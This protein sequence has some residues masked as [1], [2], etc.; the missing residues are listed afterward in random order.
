MICTL[1]TAAFVCTLFTLG[2]VRAA[3]GQMAIRTTVEPP[4]EQ[5]TK[6][7]HALFV[8]DWQ[9]ISERY[10]EF[11]TYRGDLRYN[12]RLADV[13][14]AAQAADYAQARRVISAARAL[15]A[16][17]LN[18]T[19]RVS[20]ELFIR[21]AVEGL[22]LEPH[23]GYRSLSL[24]A[25]GG[26]QSDLSYLLRVVPMSRAEHVEQLL[27]RLAAYPKRMDQE[28]ANLGSGMTAGWVA[29]KAVLDRVVLQI[30]GQMP[31]D[32]EAGPFYEPFKR[33]GSNI[34]AA[35]RTRLQA[36]GRAAIEQHVLPSMKKL[37]AFVT[38][39]Y[40]PKAPASG[41]MLQYPD[42]KTVYD[43]LVRQQTTT[44]LSAAQVHAIGLR[45]MARI[46]AEMEGVMKQVKFEGD[47]SAFIQFLNTD[48][49]FFVKSADEPLAMYRDLGERLD[50]EMPRLFA[51]LP[52]APWGV[53]AMPAH[54][55]PSAAESYD[56]PSRDGSRPGWFNANVLNLAGRPTWGLATLTAH[57]AVPGH[58]LQTA[59]ALELGALPEFRR[60]GWG[61][62]AYIEGWALYAE[63]L[64]REIGLYEDPY[65]LFGHL[66]WQAFGAGRLVVDTG[67]HSLGWSRQQ[68]INYMI[69][70]TGVA[71]G[72]VTAEVDRYI[73]WPGLALGYMVGQLK[74]VELRARANAALGDKFDVRRFHNAVL[75]NGALPL[76]TLETQIDVWIAGELTAAKAPP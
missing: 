13:S 65:A 2:A 36:A 20:R 32:I 64:G 72:F 6:A 38:D 63:T 27:A 17:R 52:R 59:R 46:R 14:P 15:P 37:R 61:Y 18:A 22:A 45:E 73:S 56:S 12:D 44:E 51:E 66:Q 47:F 34:P 75:D 3:D 71:A 39:E 10:P 19:D 67:I 28:I 31:A 70:R 23:P 41:A 74:I 30:D 50:A 9:R 49:R 69:E 53:R 16:E 5:V 1:R 48:S 54:T 42:G 62:T 29:P 35:E 25:L 76:A 7:L 57:E 8:Q 4:D 40:L 26:T 33:L 58:H 68:A 11:S 43:I 60:S 24:S 55:G 21:L